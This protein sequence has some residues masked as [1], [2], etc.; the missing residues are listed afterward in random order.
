MNNELTYLRK[1]EQAVRAK[2]GSLRS[3]VQEYE[4]ILKALEPLE[5]ARKKDNAEAAPKN[6]NLKELEVNSIRAKA[7]EQIWED[8]KR[9]KADMKKREESKSFGIS[10]LMPKFSKNGDLLN[11]E[12]MKK[13]AQAMKDYIKEASSNEKF[14]PVNSDVN[15][16]LNKSTNNY[17]LDAYFT[18]TESK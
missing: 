11:V 10:E 13:F 8:L 17:W 1:L 2:E 6:E 9:E 3:F 18:K 7:K 15:L 14:Q 12:T 4:E 16:I 5:E